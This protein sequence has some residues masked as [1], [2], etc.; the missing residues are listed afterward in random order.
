[1]PSTGTSTGT[2]RGTST[3]NG[4]NSLTA[5]TPRRSTLNSAL[6]QRRNHSV[7]L[8]R[9]VHVLAGQS[10][11]PSLTAHVPRRSTLECALAKRR[12]R[13]TNI[14]RLAQALA[15]QKR[16]PTFNIERLVRFLAGPKKQVSSHGSPP[17]RAILKNLARLGGWPRPRNVHDV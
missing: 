8:E 3:G 15:S 14:E 10:K 2:S 1:M 9:L 17:P 12:N 11:N 13:S 16:N 4:Q 7:N 6:A 5:R